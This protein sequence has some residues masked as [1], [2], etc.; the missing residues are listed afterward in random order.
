VIKIRRKWLLILLA[1]FGLISAV[2]AAP[3][4]LA[5][6]ERLWLCPISGGSYIVEQTTQDRQPVVHIHYRQ[7]GQDAQKEQEILFSTLNGKVKTAVGLGDSIFLAFDDGTMVKNGP[8][9]QVVLRSLPNSAVPVRFFADSAK[10]QLFVLAKPKTTT[11]TVGGITSWQ[12]Y[13]WDS[14]FWRLVTILPVDLAGQADPIPLVNDGRLDLFA[15]NTKTSLGHWSWQDEKWVSQ[16]TVLTQS[17]IKHYW[18]VQ[19]G[20]KITIVVA[21]PDSKSEKLA[22]YPLD[23]AK[24][25]IPLLLGTKPLELTSPYSVASDGNQIM[26]IYFSQDRRHAYLG[27]WSADGKSL[28]QAPSLKSSSGSEQSQDHST[29]MTILMVLILVAVFLTR[30]VT[31]PQAPKSP[32][33]GWIVSPFW[34]R[35]VAF[36]IDFML[37]SFVTSILLMFFDGDR[38]QVLMQDQEALRS[39]DLTHVDPEIYKLGMINLVIFAVYCVTMEGLWGWTIGKKYLKLEVRLLQNMSARPTWGQ[40]VLRNGIKIL[41]LY[42]LPLLIIM[43]LNRKRQR[44]GD[45]L[46]G[47]VVLAVDLQPEENK[48]D[49]QDEI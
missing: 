49:E 48:K 7:K 2:Q 5:E 40:V 15:K 44:I 30:G 21:S 37:I 28:G 45:I 33:A 16:P 36:L 39:F 19:V 14:G 35:G 27:Q 47:T 18:P 9:P 34:R 41:E 23:D 4:K 13:Q 46:A 38:I 26:A 43:A 10:D 12:I 17:D 3:A 6:V 32:P 1:A 8:S 20:Q 29:Y 42:L 11:Q 24:S 31:V 25:A 22:I